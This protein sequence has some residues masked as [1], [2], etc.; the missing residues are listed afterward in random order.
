MSQ[1]V[2]YL[3]ILLKVET[4]LNYD[5]LKAMHSKIEVAVKIKQNYVFFFKYKNGFFEIQNSAILQIFFWYRKDVIH[6][7]ICF[8][9]HMYCRGVKIA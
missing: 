6:K 7:V 3:F 9:K 2:Y 5:S 4:S 1:Y 8:I